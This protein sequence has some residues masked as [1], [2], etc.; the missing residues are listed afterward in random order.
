MQCTKGEGAF[1]CAQKN[2]PLNIEKLHCRVSSFPDSSDLMSAL[3]QRR[4]FR[5]LFEMFGHSLPPNRSGGNAFFGHR[6]IECVAWVLGL[7]CGQTRRFFA[8]C[9]NSAL[10]DS[11]HKRS[12]KLWQKAQ[13]YLLNLNVLH[14]F[15]GVVMCAN[16]GIFC[17]M[18]QFSAARWR[19]RVSKRAKN[20]DKKPNS[21]C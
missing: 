18:L 12:Q 9:C 7:S 2:L 6:V 1:P 15:L 21:I 16:E 11:G 13:Q 20:C 17:D 14:G 3:V 4:F 8:I 10:P 19:F 5:E